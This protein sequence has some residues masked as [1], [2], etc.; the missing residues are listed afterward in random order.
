MHNLLYFLYTGRVNLHDTRTYIPSN[1]DESPQN[2]LGLANALELLRAANMYLIEPLEERC[3]KYLANTCLVSN[4]CQRL[5]NYQ[6]KPYGKPVNAHIDF[7]VRNYG[8]IKMTDAWEN[9]FR[10]IDPSALEELMYRTDI[11]HRI[12]KSISQGER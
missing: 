10:D 3:C 2:Y 6:C 11:L 4:I 12:S 7:V 9:V 1:V 5:F 8:E